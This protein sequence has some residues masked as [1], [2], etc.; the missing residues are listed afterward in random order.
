MIGENEV[1]EKSDVF[2]IFPETICEIH[3]KTVTKP[4][5]LKRKTNPLKKFD[6]SDKTFAKTCDLELHINEN[7]DLLEHLE[8]D[9]C[10]KTFVLKWRL[11]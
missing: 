1:K 7:H 2:E 11:T 6:S 10:G 8:C 4:R 3:D 5:N 9:H